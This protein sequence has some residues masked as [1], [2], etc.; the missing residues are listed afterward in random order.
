[1]TIAET[2][3]T[4][5]KTAVSDWLAAVI[6]HTG[7]SLS[8]VAAQAEISL[9]ALTRLREGRRTLPCEPR[10]E[11]LQKLFAAFG[12]PTNG[13]ELLAEVHH[14]RRAASRR[15]HQKA[16]C[17]VCGSVEW[18]TTPVVPAGQFGVFTHKKCTER[19]S[20]PLT[21]ALAQAVS[22][23]GGQGALLASLA[24]HGVRV[25]RATVIRWSSGGAIDRPAGIVPA[26]A[27]ILGYS[28]EQEA[29]LL[30][31]CIEQR[32][33][34]RSKPPW[35]PPARVA[36]V[37]GCGR[38]ALLRVVRH[39]KH[40]KPP[41]DW[42]CSACRAQRSKV[43]QV[44]R[45]ALTGLCP[46]A[47]LP[48]RWDY[49][50][51]R[52]RR[53]P[54]HVM[55]AGNVA[56]VVP[57]RLH[58]RIPK[59]WSTASGRE[60]RDKALVVGNP[61]FTGF[62]PWYEAHPIYRMHDIDGQP[63][64]ALEVLDLARGRDVHDAR[65]KQRD[66]AK[67]I[68]G[69][70]TTSLLRS[71]SRRPTARRRRRRSLARRR[72][73]GV[74]GVSL[75]RLDALA[76]ATTICEE[77]GQI[78]GASSRS[79]RVRFH[80]VC[81]KEHEASPQF[82]AALWERRRN[83]D[84]PGRGTPI[85]SPRSPW[86]RRTP[87]DRPADHQRPVGDSEISDSPATSSESRRFRRAFVLA[88]RFLAGRTSIS[89]L[90]A[91][92]GVAKHS[93]KVAIRSILARLPT[94][95]SLAIRARGIRARVETGLTDTRTRRLLNGITEK[96]RVAS[97]RKRR[98]AS[99]RLLGRL[100]LVR[101][102]PP[103][104]IAALVTGFTPPQITQ[105]LLCARAECGIAHN[106]SPDVIYVKEGGGRRSKRRRGKLNSAQLQRIRTAPARRGILAELAREFGVTRER[107]RQIRKPIALDSAATA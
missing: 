79:Q 96:R 98:V 27:G 30:R 104:H 62:G 74:H 76:A 3:Q 93:V 9:D 1:M 85:V 43:Q 7:S 15:R 25:T 11:S 64:E 97:L 68:V 66:R 80:D 45:L 37:G 46:S 56:R 61:N 99:L 20:T 51:K 39:E 29:D 101:D 42:T 35:K 23:A 31:Y 75:R 34:T 60:K 12:Q 83:P 95:L 6:A 84:H 52:I 55:P 91:E 69:I 72:V 33:R 38:T 90:A 82:R 57:C 40:F 50:T 47:D 73:I 103:E 24:S 102:M 44:C 2:R 70:W 4:S 63:L 77:C 78:A 14:Q 17:T 94:D 16:K 54:T 92:A 71:K 48:E 59:P 10:I 5:V 58:R 67:E 19:P 49:E 89:K 28:L 107:I 81:W 22:V 65:P 13:A 8:E 88:I 105:L 41:A 21:R 32:E 26:V 106:C 86:W 87:T 53:Y 36:C 100:G 18:R